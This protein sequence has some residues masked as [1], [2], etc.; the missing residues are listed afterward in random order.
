MHLFSLE[1]KNKIKL[2][3]GNFTIKNLNSQIGSY[4][5]FVSIGL[6][7][8]LSGLMYVTQ[9]LN[10]DPDFNIFNFR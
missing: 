8:G 3:L 1:D 6:F 9:C 5:K 7:T 4:S 10:G 2:F